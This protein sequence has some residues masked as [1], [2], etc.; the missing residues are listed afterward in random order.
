[1][2]E[3][4]REKRRLALIPLFLSLS[5]FFSLL[6]NIRLSELL[7]FVFTTYIASGATA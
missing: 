5:F 4:E 1:M 3:K 2:R 6:L 7:R